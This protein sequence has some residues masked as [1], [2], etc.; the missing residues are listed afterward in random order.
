MSG[1]LYRELKALLGREASGHL[2][3]HMDWEGK[4]LIL[5]YSE[6][7]PST[8]G[9]QKIVSIKEMEAAIVGPEKVIANRLRDMKKELDGEPVEKRPRPM[10]IL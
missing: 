5:H 4:T 3:V 1:E 10:S 9:V 8:R 7:G 6:K 2:T